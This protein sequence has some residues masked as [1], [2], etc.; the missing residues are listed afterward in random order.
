MEQYKVA[1]NLV[2]MMTVPSGEID[3]KMSFSCVPRIPESLSLAEK[4]QKFIN[5][6]MAMN[7]DNSKLTKKEMWHPQVLS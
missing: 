4:Y 7:A 2:E 5:H 3:V 1:C 6:H